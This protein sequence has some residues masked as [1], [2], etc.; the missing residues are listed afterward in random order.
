[1]PEYNGFDPVLAA[2]KAADAPP[3]EKK[4]RKDRR[5]ASS[6]KGN[7]LS[8]EQA[9]RQSHVVRTAFLALDQARAIAFLNDHDEALGGRP[10]DLALESAEGLAAVERALKARS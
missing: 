5:F 7:R 10:L 2:E 4:E 8:P 3:G 9:Q 1:M 6:A